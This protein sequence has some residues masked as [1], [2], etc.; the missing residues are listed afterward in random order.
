MRYLHHLNGRFPPTHQWQKNPERGNLAAYV[1]NFTKQAE[2]FRITL[3][4]KQAYEQHYAESNETIRSRYFPNQ[5]TLWSEKTR[6]YADSTIKLSDIDNI[7][8]A[9]LKMF[10]EV[11]ATTQQQSQKMNNPTTAQLTSTF[12]PLDKQRD[13]TISIKALAIRSTLS[14]RYGKSSISTTF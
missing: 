13:R 11:W 9:C 7:D 3:E 10:A 2:P 14:R 12:P 6:Q 4:Q 5:S 8:L 1:H